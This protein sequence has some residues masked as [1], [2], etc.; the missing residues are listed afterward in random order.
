MFI[1]NNIYRGL[2]IFINQRVFMG[3][4]SL[5]HYMLSKMVEQQLWA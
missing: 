2:L 5:H 3:S 4:F 1:V